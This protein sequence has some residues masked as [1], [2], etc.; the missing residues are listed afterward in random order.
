MVELELY[1]LTARQQFLAD[2]L[3]QLEEYDDVQAFIATLPDREACECE[4]IIEMMRLAL[5][6][7]YAEG[8][9]DEVPMTEAQKLIDKVRK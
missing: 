2:I 6:E 5:V 9:A 1:G 8:M 7:Q 4:S 3:W